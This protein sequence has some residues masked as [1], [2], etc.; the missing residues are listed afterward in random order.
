MIYTH[1]R[2][3]FRNLDL[4][5][6]LRSKAF[7]IAGVTYQK[8]SYFES[9]RNIA[10]EVV[11]I[12][13][14]T[15]QKKYFQNATEFQPHTDINKIKLLSE[16]LVNFH[17]ISVNNLNENVPKI[18]KQEQSKPKIVYST[19][20]EQKES[21]KI[22]N[23]AILELKTNILNLLEKFRN[24]NTWMEPYKNEVPG[25]TKSAYIEFLSSLNEIVED[26]DTTTDID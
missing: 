20:D 8:E 9:Q 26:I 19:L 18:L 7:T 21:E 2:Q 5:N 22:E 16:D 17:Q 24:K 23:L 4:M 6:K 13:A 3:S 11:K 15:R 10:K 25:K 1:W 12:Q 14:L